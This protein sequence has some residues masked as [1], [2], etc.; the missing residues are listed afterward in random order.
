MPTAHAD[1]SNE[2]KLVDL[3]FQIALMLSETKGTDRE[4]KKLTLYKLPVP[5]KAEWIAQQL[6]LCGFPTTPCGS[7]WGV[8]L[9]ENPGLDKI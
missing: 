9:S 6:S 2:Q 7:S 5:K 8:L 3:C 4:G 1:R